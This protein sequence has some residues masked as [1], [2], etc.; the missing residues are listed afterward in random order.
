[1]HFRSLLEH[2][3][4]EAAV[5]STSTVPLVYWAEQSETVNLQNKEVSFAE[6]DYARVVTK[7]GYYNECSWHSIFHIWQKLVDFASASKTR[8]GFPVGLW[9]WKFIRV[10]IIIL[11][12]HIRSRPYSTCLNSKTTTTR[13]SRFESIKWITS[14]RILCGTW[15][16][17]IHFWIGHINQQVACLLGW[18][19]PRVR[20]PL[21]YRIW[22][23]SQMT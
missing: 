15:Q 7:M 1:M 11:C 12:K 19:L 5:H 21:P 2:Q 22:V 8:Q 3:H 10:I 23:N 6:S 13:T 16:W 9:T 17:Q 20:L 18:C 4:A 14:P